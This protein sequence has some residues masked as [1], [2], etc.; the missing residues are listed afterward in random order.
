[1]SDFLIKNDNISCNHL[2]IN[3][4][5]FPINYGIDG[6]L[7]YSL[8]DDKLLWEG[9]EASLDIN[10]EENTSGIRDNYYMIMNDSIGSSSGKFTRA[11]TNNY[12]R[13]G[14]GNNTSGID[15]GGTGISPLTKGQ[16]TIGLTK[17]DTSSLSVIKS[18]DMNTGYGHTLTDHLSLMSDGIKLTNNKERKLEDL[19]SG[20]FII[21]NNY[22]IKIDKEGYHKYED[23]NMININNTTEDLYNKIIT[24]PIL[25]GN[26]IFQEGNTNVELGFKSGGLRLLILLKTIL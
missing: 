26:I 4:K 21:S 15:K 2:K 22:G 6:F 8:S 16:I 19:S 12:L 23:G 7:K 18:L 14:M 20:D 10:N 1:M 9:L 24:D 3:G 5:L 25:N 13:I 11:I 17:E